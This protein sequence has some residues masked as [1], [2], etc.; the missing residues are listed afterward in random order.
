MRLRRPCFMAPHAFFRL[1]S[2]PLTSIGKLDRRA[3]PDHA[4][5]HLPGNAYEAPQREV[6]IALA[7]ICAR[8]RG[9]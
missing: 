4:P 2:L 6:E 7:P 3:L 8:A 9:I 5:A 1:A